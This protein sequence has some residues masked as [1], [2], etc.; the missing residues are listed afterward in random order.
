MD[1]NEL[2]TQPMSIENL[3][4]FLPKYA[5]AVLYK[6]LSSSKKEAFSDNVDCVIVLYETKINKFW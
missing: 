4:K 3:R 5:K 1:L 2:K 6:T